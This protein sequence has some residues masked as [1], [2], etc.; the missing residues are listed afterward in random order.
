MWTPFLPWVLWG[1][2][3]GEV[4]EFSAPLA[5]EHHGSLFEHLFPGSVLS[6]GAGNVKQ[7]TRGFVEE[8]GRFES[9]L[10]LPVCH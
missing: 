3:W 2:C 10:G 8:H 4:L 5:L 7:W 9:G 1:W 6:S